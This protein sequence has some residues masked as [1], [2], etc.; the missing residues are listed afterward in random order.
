MEQARHHAAWEQALHH[1]AWEK[2]RQNTI[3]EKARH[4]T[5]WKKKDNKG[6]IMTK[7]NTKKKT[8][9]IIGAS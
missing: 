8:K 9:H 3:W 2:K 5:T 1:K 4:H 6:I 7:H